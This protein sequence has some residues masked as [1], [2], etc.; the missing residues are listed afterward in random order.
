MNLFTQSCDDWRIENK[1]WDHKTNFQFHAT[2]SETQP[3]IRST[4]DRS[5]PSRGSGQTEENVRSFIYL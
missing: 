1:L 3:L 2:M 4:S 5:F